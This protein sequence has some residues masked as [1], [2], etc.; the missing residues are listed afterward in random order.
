MALPAWAQIS[1]LDPL[2]S[3]RKDRGEKF[4]KDNNMFFLAN[5]QYI[6]PDSFPQSCSVYAPYLHPDRP[7]VNF[8]VKQ[9]GA[10]FPGHPFLSKHDKFRVADDLDCTALWLLACRQ[11]DSLAREVHQLMGDFA[12][13]P[14]RPAR[15]APRTVRRWKCYNTW[16][17]ERMPL[18]LDACVV[19]NV[20]SFVAE[21]DLE[22]TV[23]DSASIRFLKWTLQSG[24][25]ERKP[26]RISPSYRR[27]PVILYH[28]A[29]VEE[30][31]P[32]L[33]T[34]DERAL[35]RY[36]AQQCLLN[37]ELNFFDRCILNTSIAQWGGVGLHPVPEKLPENWEG[38]AE[39]F[40]YFH[41]HLT[42]TL[43]PFLAHWWGRYKLF[44]WPYSNKAHCLALFHQAR[45]YT[46]IP[47]PIYKD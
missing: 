11:P 2:H 1:S 34:Q 46:R 22:P 40:A 44:S 10:Q 39:D 47:Y 20:L 17:A 28:Y 24:Y 23:H 9:P 13:G 45:Q 4:R 31:W 18:E 41:A 43:P 16:F 37:E 14:N 36:L 35:L 26:Q 27:L 15:H 42:S 5:A 38:E 12:A 25:L 32:G 8:Y 3:L 7:T 19:A 6:L 33:F 30:V 29:R 21:Y